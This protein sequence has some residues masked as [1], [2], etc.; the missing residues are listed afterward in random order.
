MAEDEII[1]KHAKAAYKAWRDPEKDWKHKLREILLEVLIIVF[2]VTVSIWLHNWSESIKDHNEE[3]EFLKGLKG[4]IQA[5][6]KEMNNDRASLRKGFWA[7]RYFEVVGAGQLLNKDS[8]NKNV[9]IFFSQAQINPRIGRYEA[10]K[11]SGRVDIIIN[12][13]LQYDI[14]DLYQ[15]NFPQ[16]FRLNA[17]MNSL[18][19]DKVDPYVGDYISFDNKGVANAQEMLRKPKMRFLLLQCEGFNSSVG[20]YSD[21]ISKGNEIIKEI[22][23]ELQ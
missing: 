23:K 20:A 21:G 9:W 11:A 5:D 8:L 19:T 10:L 15:K 14:I 13:K 12:K 17:F 7:V 1:K 18:I 4:D 22:D 6:L 2:A 16:I 3:K